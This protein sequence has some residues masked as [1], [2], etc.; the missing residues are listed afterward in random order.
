MKVWNLNKETASTSQGTQIQQETFLWD[1]AG[2]NDY[3]IVHQLFVDQTSLGL[4]L[5]DPT[6]P[7]ET[8]PGVQHWVRALQRATRN[9]IPRLLVAGRIDRGSL[10]ISD[11]ELRNILSNYRFSAYAATSAKTG[12]GVQDL[13]E[14]IQR[15]IEWDQLPITHSPKLW[16][17]LRSFVL[18]RREQE[19]VLARISDLKLAF[20]LSHPQHVVSD[21]AFDTV[22]A[23]LQAQ[24]IVWRFSFG[25]LLLLR[26]ELLNDYASAVVLAARNHPMGLGAVN[27]RDVLDAR[28][29]LSVMDR[30]TNPQAERSLL[31][32]VVERFLECQIALREGEHLVFPSKLNLPKPEFN[33][34]A[35]LDTVIQFQGPGEEI[36]A[37]LIVKLASG[38]A[39]ELCQAWRGGAAFRDTLG[40][41]CGVSVELRGATDHQMSLYFHKDTSLESR[42]LFS[43]FSYD[44]LHRRAIEGSVRR[45]RVFRCGRCGEEV[46]NPKAIAARI[47][48]GR[49]TIVCQFCDANVPIVDD[50]EHRFADPAILKE[51]RDLELSERKVR[52]GEVGL[53][54]ASAK[55]EI[56]EFDVFLAYNSFDEKPVEAVA[57]ALRRRGLN[58]WFAK[59]TLPPGR[60]FQR[61]IQRVF[62]DVQSVVVFIGPNGVG[63]WEDLEIQTAIQMFVKRRVPV[64]PALLPGVPSRTE[65]PLFLGEFIMVSF[66]KGLDDI[67][68]LDRLEWGITGVAPRRKWTHY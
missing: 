54:T 65:L 67:A 46:R 59:W 40:H 57:E 15:H 6:D 18:A 30:I 14:L 41:I 38:G 1:L 9:E 2:Q 68:A 64:I 31:H 17:E 35:S 43:R 29:D 23:H 61:E 37:T 10:T 19:D 22:I 39:F 25:N 20:C 36:Y 12:T 33:E 66:E 49:T 11:L 51:V 34:H 60:Q 50:I 26:P 21:R 47:H 16:L 28:I 13:H 53:T 3:Q 27:E 44:H 52:D 5:F 32:A 4:V 45:E 7:G 63:P 24:G 42:L 8:L 56:E 55:R 48:A 62:F 58:P